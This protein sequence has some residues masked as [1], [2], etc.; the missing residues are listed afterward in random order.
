MAQRLSYICEICLDQNTETIATPA[1]VVIDETGAMLDL[2]STHRAQVL[3]P[4]LKLLR[5]SGRPVTGSSVTA[6]PAPPVTAGPPRPAPAAAPVSVPHT[7]TLTPVERPQNRP[8]TRFA[9]GRATGPFVPERPTAP[10]PVPVTGERAS[11]DQGTTFVEPTPAPVAEPVAAVEPDPAWLDH[12]VPVET[13]PERLTGWPCPGC[14]GD[15]NAEPFPS[16][17]TLALHT[18][19]R[20]HVKMTDVYAAIG[21]CRFPGCGYDPEEHGDDGG[22]LAAHVQLDHDV[23]TLATMIC[24]LALYDP[25]RVNDLLMMFW[26]ADVQGTLV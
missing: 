14:L 19:S 8:R 2:C 21:K 13:L 26:A 4:L 22:S 11:I 17:T 3:E 25:F 24:L 10:G 20:H 7:S 9:T 23:M 1:H 16:P 12:P 15:E 18:V 6:A 5:D